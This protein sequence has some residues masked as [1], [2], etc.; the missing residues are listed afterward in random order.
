MSQPLP[1]SYP[2]S[3]RK[4]GG[5]SLIAAVF[6]IVVLAALGAFAVQVAMTQYQTSNAEL[7]ESRVEV[8]AETGIEYGAYLALQ[9]PAN[10]APAAPL[11]L[12][13][14][15]LTGYIVTVN[16]NQ[17][18]HQIGMPPAVTTVSIYALK[19]S[20]SFG[21]YGKPDYVARTVTRN[22]TTAPP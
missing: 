19:A 9:A 13:Q 7:L 6:L 22:V 11:P 3:A 10:C 4:Q 14:G 17:T 18:T 5:F 1:S 12:S 16:C 15:T 20:A 2:D 21:T 8:A